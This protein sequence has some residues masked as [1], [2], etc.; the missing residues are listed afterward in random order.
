MLKNEFG[1]PE[2]RVVNVDQ[3]TCKLI[4]VQSGKRSELLK[5]F[6]TT[7]APTAQSF[8]SPFD[9]HA[10]K[11][12]TSRPAIN[13]TPHALREDV[14]RLDHHDLRRGPA[15]GALRGAVA[16]AAQGQVLQ[17]LGRE[18]LLGSFSANCFA[19]R[20]SLPVPSPVCRVRARLNPIVYPV[21]SAAFLPLPRL[22]DRLR[23]RRF[24][25]GRRARL[26]CLGGGA[27]AACRARGVE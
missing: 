7:R 12:P 5:R 25:C 13:T 19:L 14:L 17:G 20:R 2:M 26:G 15:R 27:A 23:A 10:T 3:S 11:S 9:A 22:V 1:L 24:F 21:S 8:T 16:G 6:L 18:Q 4:A